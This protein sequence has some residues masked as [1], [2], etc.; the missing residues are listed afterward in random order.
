MELEK[1]EKRIEKLRREEQGIV[2]SCKY[3]VEAV[4]KTREKLNSC[5]AERRKLEAERDI[6]LDRRL[7][8]RA[9]LAR[10]TPNRVELMEAWSLLFTAT[11]IITW[12]CSVIASAHQDSQPAVAYLGAGIGLGLIWLPGLVA[13]GLFEFAKSH[14]AKHYPLYAATRSLIDESFGQAKTRLEQVSGLGGVAKDL[15]LGFCGFIAIGDIACFFLADFICL[16]IFI[17]FILSVGGLL[18]ISGIILA[19]TAKVLFVEFKLRLIVYRGLK[20]V[21]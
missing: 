18:V 16:S 17:G 9:A 1:I 4:Q 14:L 7:N 8:Q 3:S 10:Q 5:R 2:N 11:F 19:D 20:Q 15:S 6:I 12:L 13:V 21:F